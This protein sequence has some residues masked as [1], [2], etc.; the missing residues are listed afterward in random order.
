MPHSSRS[1]PVLTFSKRVPMLA[2]TMNSRFKAYWSAILSLNVPRPVFLHARDSL[3]SA[4]TSVSRALEFP[5]CDSSARDLLYLSFSATFQIHAMMQT[6]ILYTSHIRRWGAGRY[7]EILYAA[8]AGGKRALRTSLCA[9]ATLRAVAPSVDVT[10]KGSVPDLDP[11]QE[12]L[13]ALFTFVQQSTRFERHSL[14]E[15]KPKGNCYC[16]LRC[17]CAVILLGYIQQL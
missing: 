3:R 4:E 7:L 1:S 16:N 14:V 11:L 6:S 2:V 5:V 8:R 15:S 12:S 17:S 9:C 10:R 13:I